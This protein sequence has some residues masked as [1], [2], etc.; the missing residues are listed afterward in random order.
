MDEIN[1]KFI[2]WSMRF[3]I[4]SIILAVLLAVTPV[5][6][7]GLG[8]SVCAGTT[9]CCAPGT[10]M[11]HKD[12][13]VKIDDGMC[14]CG[15]SVAA[16]CG[17][18]KDI[19]IGLHLSMGALARSDIQTPFRTFV[20]PVN[21]MSAETGATPGISVVISFLAHNSPPPYLLSCTFII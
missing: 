7:V 1:S 5:Y 10:G 8:C 19:P 20:S 6:G 12:I 4:V 3:P 17:I 16:H 2:V 14:C 15:Q 13:S 11:H 9:C 21:S 18:L